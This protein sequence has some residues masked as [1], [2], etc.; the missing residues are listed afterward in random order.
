MKRQILVGSLILL[1]GAVITEGLD[2]AGSPFCDLSQ[3]G[4][5]AYRESELVVRFR[6]AEAG[7]EAAVAR[8]LRHD[9]PRCDGALSRGDVDGELV[10]EGRGVERRVPAGRR[11]DGQPAKDAIGRTV[12]DPMMKRSVCTG[13]VGAA[14][15]LVDT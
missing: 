5:S 14:L 11:P 8:V 9:P 13:P 15:L 10:G 2:F 7:S 12:A 3:D 4:I 1:L 6:D